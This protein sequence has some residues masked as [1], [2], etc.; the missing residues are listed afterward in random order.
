MGILFGEMAAEQRCAIEVWL[1]KLSEQAAER[2][3]R[4]IAENKSR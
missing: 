1:R 2:E 4:S 3:P